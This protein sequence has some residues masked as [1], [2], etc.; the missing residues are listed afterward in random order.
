MEWYK[1]LS[2]KAFLN[3]LRPVDI[4]WEGVKPSI[5]RGNKTAK[6]LGIGVGIEPD[7]KIVTVS[8]QVRRDN[9]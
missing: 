7:N 1:N 9:K 2:D 8:R 6:D 4:K 3:I 5:E